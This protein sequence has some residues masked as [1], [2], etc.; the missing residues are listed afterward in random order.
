MKPP[1]FFTAAIL[2]IGVGIASAQPAGAP[3]V[4]RAGG[5]PPAPTRDPLAAGYVKATELP[6]GQVPPVEADG[7]FIIG[8][9]HA[10]SPEMSPVGDD[11]P[12]GDIYKFTLRSTESKFYPGIARDQPAPG[13]AGSA[14]ANGNTVTSHAEPWMRTV[15]VYVP[16]QYVPG[17]VCTTGCRP[18]RTW[19]GY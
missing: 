5:R 11:A 3:A 15:S 16:K 18:T 19:P 6:D 12:K 4:G 13:A 7:N 1:F 8:P 2:L 14:G 10:P 17:M 9:T